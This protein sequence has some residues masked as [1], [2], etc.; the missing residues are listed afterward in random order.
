[1]SGGRLLW[2]VAEQH[3]E[4]L[5]GG[6]YVSGRKTTAGQRAAAAN[7]CVGVLQRGRRAVGSRPEVSGWCRQ[8]LLDG[9]GGARRRCGKGG[10]TVLSVGGRLGCREYGR[11]I[12]WVHGGVEVSGAGGPV[13][14]RSVWVGVMGMYG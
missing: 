7:E 14:R 9:G 6:L 5:R 13:M 3:D 1:M 4:R 11:A 12:V 10:G 2:L 8:V